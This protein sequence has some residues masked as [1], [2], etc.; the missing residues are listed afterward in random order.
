MGVYFLIILIGVVPGIRHG[1]DFVHQPALLM[2]CVRIL[3][4]QVPFRDFYPWYGP[5]FHYF[6]ALWVWI[7]GQDLL[8]IKIFLVV[9]SPFV[10]MAML[11]WTVRA[12]GLAWPGRLFAVVSSAVIGMDRI[13]HCGSTR[14]LLGLFF[15]GLWS[16][17][18]R[19]T[20]PGRIRFLVFPSV[21]I[22]FFYSPEVG[23]YLL[24]TAAG[25]LAWDL[26]SGMPPGRSRAGRNYALGAGAALGVFALLFLGTDAVKNYLRFFSYTSSNM[27]WAYGR[28]KPSWDEI[29]A[30]PRYF[31]YLLPGVTAV[32]P[33]FWMARKML[34]GETAQIPVWAPAL[35]VYGVLLWT[36]TFVALS[37]DHLLFSLPPILVLLS[38]Y[39]QGRTRWHW[40]QPLLIALIL[41]AAPLSH[42]SSLNFDYWAVRFTPQTAWKASA[43]WGRLYV[44]PKYAETM[45][46]LQKFS[47]EHPQETIV[48]PIHGFEAFRL[49]R[50]LLLPFDDLFWINEPNRQHEFLERFRQLH[51]DYVAMDYDYVFQLYL[52][53]DIDA[54]FDYIAAHYQP[55]RT[56]GST[57]IYQKM[58]EPRQ[59]AARVQTLPGPYPLA[60]R[61]QF[62][63]EWETPAGFTSGYIELQEK[64]T[65]RWNWLQ[66]FSVPIV[67]IYHDGQPCKRE[68]LFLGPQRIRTTPA[69]GEVR[70]L[71]PEGT[72]RV[73]AIITF[74]G[75]LNAH[76]EQVDF[77]NVQ[78]Y[79]FLFKPQLPYTHTFLDQGC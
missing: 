54:L 69:G 37:P 58:A 47:R 27:I 16:Q 21:L 6:L 75:I 74:P 64:F 76:P 56:I 38:W 23:L 50:P 26:W 32:P 35:I 66:R 10:S 46:A 34:R 11:V 41:Y 15:I 9:I 60:A 29:L 14:S 4:G 65:Y 63:V 3:D 22:M 30:Y 39:F 44:I 28:T 73:K 67:E 62:S 45:D 12:L 31:L 8:S 42:M 1:F 59:L 57:L 5:L 7:L 17:G 43:A 18:L 13:Y 78:F 61:N 79:Q 51:A 72:R 19:Q 77:W 48:F 71:V 68:L 53:E 52:H 40:H 33:L 2:S 20:H 24:F 70:F 49:G 36:T 55:L 25:F